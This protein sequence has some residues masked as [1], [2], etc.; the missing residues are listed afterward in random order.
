[1]NKINNK[2]ENFNYRLDLVEVT[3]SEPETQGFF[4]FPNNP[5]RLKNK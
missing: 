2:I 4:F 1:M 5:V 3:I